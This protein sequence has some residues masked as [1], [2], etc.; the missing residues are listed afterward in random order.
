METASYSAVEVLGL[1]LWLRK[2][3]LV[4]NAVR[5]GGA[6]VDACLAVALAKAGY[7]LTKQV[8]GRL[9]RFRIGHVVTKTTGE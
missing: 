8:C 3:E 4:I 7:A 1:M 9:S 6:K 2:S 5:I